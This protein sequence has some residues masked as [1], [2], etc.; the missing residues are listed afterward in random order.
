M[1]INMSQTRV[2]DSSKR[3]K[4]LLH[5]MGFELTCT[6]CLELSTRLLGFNGWDSY[7]RQHDTPS[8]RWTKTSRKRSSGRGTSF[9]WEC[10]K[11]RDLERWRETAR[12]M[13][14]HRTA[15]RKTAHDPGWSIAQA[16][17]R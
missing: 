13:R 1:S 5:D 14:S 12:S 8:V 3:L 7:W 2:K 10:S 17:P 6:D 4:K 15:I 11:P 9:R 16:A